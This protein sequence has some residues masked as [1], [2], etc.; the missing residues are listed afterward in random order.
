ML[1]TVNMNTQHRT[2]LYLNNYQFSTL[3]QKAEREKKSMAAVVR[4]AIDLVLEEESKENAKNR[5][6][7]WKKFFK[8]A[9]IGASGLG[10]LSYNH[11]KYYT[12]GK[13]GFC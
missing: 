9:G 4:E 11:D 13:K 1:Y 10:D 8:L 5:E 6:K 2:Q 12:Y 3:K 7:E